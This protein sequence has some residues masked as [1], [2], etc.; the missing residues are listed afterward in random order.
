ML[1]AEQQY[2]R[3]EVRG[4]ETDMAQS[5][6]PVDPALHSPLLHVDGVGRQGG[7]RLISVIQFNSE[8]DLLFARFLEIFDVVGEG[9]PCPVII[10]IWRSSTLLFS[11]CCYL[12][13][14]RSNCG[15]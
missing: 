12:S 13:M 2:I 1:Q 8:V 11:S 6:C 3:I 9:K 14:H 5:F 10:A 15:D 7:H 4:N